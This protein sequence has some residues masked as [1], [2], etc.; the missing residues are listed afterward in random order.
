MSIEEMKSFIRDHFEEFVNHKNLDIADVNFA[1]DF[2]DHAADVPPGTP[3]GPWSRM[4]HE[5]RTKILFR[6][7]DLLDERSD[8][9]AIHVPRKA[10]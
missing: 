8:E 3:P 5:E 7:A 6:I 9:F 1:T 2:V 4:H 10:H